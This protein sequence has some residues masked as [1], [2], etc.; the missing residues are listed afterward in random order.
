MDF[1]AAA[2]VSYVISMNHGS[3]V[4]KISLEIIEFHSFFPLA[5]VWMYRLF[6]FWKGEQLVNLGQMNLINFEPAPR[7]DF[8]SNFNI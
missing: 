5:L 7:Q 2:T 6:T 8:G 1:Q 4:L 3:M